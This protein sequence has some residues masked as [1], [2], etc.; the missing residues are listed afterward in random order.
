[1]TERPGR[2]RLTSEERRSQLLDLG[3]RL[4]SRRSLPEI[5]IDL[6]AETAGISRGLLYH[7]FGGLAGFQ[8]AV[9][10]RAADDLIARTAP[11]ASGDAISRLL[12]SIDAYVSYVDEHYEGYLSLVAGARSGNETLRRIYDEGRSAL[13]DR[14]F[15]SDTDNL[16]PDS[17]TARLLVRGWASM[18]EEMVLEWK[19]SGGGDGGAVSRDELLRLIT[20]ALPAL[21]SELSG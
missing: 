16:L 4:F 11:P 10:R 7:Y 18:A 13:T 21:A 12:T 14:I 1:M 20:A 8:E 6:L 2:T 9:V 17:P 3:V 19:A 5:S 15:T